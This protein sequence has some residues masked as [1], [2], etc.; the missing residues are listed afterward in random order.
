[1]WWEDIKIWW[2]VLGALVG[3]V[4]WVWSRFESA[5]PNQWLLLVRNGQLIKAGIGIRLWRR[6]GDMVVYFTSTMQRVT[7]ETQ[8][9]TK[10]NQP[11]VLRG[12]VLWSVSDGVG[13]PFLAF[14]KLGIENK[15]GHSKDGNFHHA[16]NRA[17]YQAF[18]RILEASLRKGVVHI[19]LP[20]L[21][22]EP[23]TLVGSVE[24]QLR[25]AVL[26]WGVK[27][28]TLEVT[29]VEVVES[30][31]FSDLQAAYVE[32]S[33]RDALKIRL[34]AKKRRDEMELEQGRDLALKRAQTQ[35]E[36]EVQ[37]AQIALEKEEEKARLFEQELASRKGQL[38]QQSALDE[39]QLEAQHKLEEQRVSLEY[40]RR[41]EEERLQ[42]S[43]QEVQQQRLMQET[44]ARVER[45][46]L[47]EQA[48]LQK[49]AEHDALEE[50]KS[51]PVRQAE[52]QK[53]MIQE[54][55]EALRGLPLRDIR[56]ISTGEQ[57]GPSG[58]LTG[59]FDSLQQ[60]VES[61]G[62]PSDVHIAEPFA[63]ESSLRDED[64]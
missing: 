19:P 64:L 2:L 57:G 60:L 51:V 13:D 62:V 50:K 27:L 7:F 3:L 39:L 4:A 63:M 36:Q 38:A 33:R 6:L 11:V 8:V 44:K 24:E 35:R 49:Q 18:R 1:M 59:L 10:E 28:E 46:T 42:A 34:E 9:F 31:L 22:A 20:T 32:E 16:L 55:A 23:T 40:A 29:G 61:R 5:E 15:R 12:F 41:L 14:S 56:W 54:T 52:I 48:Q 45:E 30:S 58:I 43:L 37:I 47:L 21:L 17:Q 53:M 26:G 25:A